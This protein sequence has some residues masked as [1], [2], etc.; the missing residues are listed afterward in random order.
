MIKLKYSSISTL[1][2]LAD[3]AA[4]AWSRAL[5]GQVDLLPTSVK[6]ADI[7][8]NFGRVDRS[9]SPNRVAQCETRGSIHLITLA[10]DIQWRISWWQRFLGTGQEDAYAALLH[11][12]GHALGLPHSNRT[13]D[14]MAPDLGTTVISDDEAQRYRS[15]LAKP[16]YTFATP[17]IP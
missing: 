8:I 10:S 17:R 11:E 5:P 3:K 1:A 2:D 7:I 12:F 13:S 9:T 16:S 4:R 15:F 6:V 14:V